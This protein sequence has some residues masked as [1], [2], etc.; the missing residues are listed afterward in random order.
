M[1]IVTLALAKKYTDTHGGA[2][3]LKFK[4][5][6]NFEDLPTS[7]L[8]IGDMYDIL[9][10]FTLDDKSY[11]AGTNVAWT[12][13]NWDALSGNIDL[14]IEP[15]K[16][17]IYTYRVESSSKYDSSTPFENSLPAILKDCKKNNYDSFAIVII[18]KESYKGSFENPSHR[19]IIFP[20]LGLD[21]HDSATVYGREISPKVNYHA[22]NYNDKD[23]KMFLTLV[24]Y[25]LTYRYLNG[26]YTTSIAVTGGTGEFYS[27]LY[28]DSLRQTIEDSIDSVSTA[29]EEL[30]PQKLIDDGFIYAK[31][32]GSILID[33]EIENPTQYGF[34]WHEDEED[35]YY[36]STNKY[37][38]DS[39][40][41]CKVIFN[42]EEEANVPITYVNYAE[43]NY[44]YGIFSQVD[45]ELSQSTNDDGASGSSIVFKN[46]K[47]ES[48][49]E[50]KTLIYTIP[51]GEHFITIKYKKDSSSEDGNDCLLFKI[52]NEAPK[53][54]NVL[55]HNT[56]KE[57]VDDAIAS[58]ITTT[59]EGEY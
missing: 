37:I 31:Q 20:K 53:K 6:C 14:G 9:N 24:S 18:P 8:E 47:S 16:F 5:S 55:V 52:P 17:K 4:G 2:S 22:W 50:E 28:I 1:D 45:K 12:G 10:D 59:L 42:L 54:V 43:Q 51:A 23:A 40:A 36:L 30:N 32:E 38:D 58:A 13:E 49:D 7:D 46:C 57:Y 25:D 41:W 11:S 27:A 33:Y 15:S 44:D 21:S 56:T 35:A 29:I 39:Y 3:A 19:I 26:E 34:V 48:S